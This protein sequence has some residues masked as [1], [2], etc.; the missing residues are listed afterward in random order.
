MQLPFFK[1]RG[2][3]L[4]CYY[5]GTLNIDISPYTF[6]MKKAE[7][8]FPKVEWTQKH[9]PEDFSFSQCRV[10]HNSKT[11]D[12][13]IYYPHP[14]TKIRH[15]QNDSLIEVIAPHIP[16]LQYGDKIELEIRFD[17]VEVGNNHCTK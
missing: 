10:I 15:H 3:D 4:S 14:E 7:L 6:K 11:Y 12:S 8:H 17:E 9:P 1:Q 5:S 13:W 2:L 16:R